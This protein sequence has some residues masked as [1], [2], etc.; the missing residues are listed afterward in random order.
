MHWYFTIGGCDFLALNRKLLEILAEGL[1][2]N[3]KNN[4][5][6]ILATEYGVSFCS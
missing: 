6:K 4:P 2:P 3:S 5:Q 1:E